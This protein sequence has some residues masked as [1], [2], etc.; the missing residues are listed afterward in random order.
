MTGGG[1]G[2]ME[3]GNRGAYEAGGR[4]IGVSIELPH[5]KVGNGYQTVILKAKDFGPRKEVLRTNDLAVVEKRWNRFGRRNSEIL[6]HLQT[7]MKEPTPVY[8]MYEKPYQ[9][10]DRMMKEME[11]QGLISKGDR[12]L[13][14]MVR[15]PH[16]I[17]T[18]LRARRAPIQIHPLNTA[19]M[20]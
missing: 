6:T 12:D 14:R 9:H 5:E 13:Y 19:E 8:I 4:S 1:P 2:M 20:S 11:K 3:A 16:D 7:R 18:D 10:F 17:I 15:S